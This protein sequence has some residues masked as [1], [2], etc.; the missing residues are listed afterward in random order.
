MV[1]RVRIK[2]LLD[3]DRASA[4]FKF[5]AANSV[6][7]NLKPAPDLRDASCL[8]FHLNNP[9]PSC[10]QPFARS[11]MSH[12]C[13][14]SRSPSTSLSIAAIRKSNTAIVRIPLSFGGGVTD[15]REAGKP[16]LRFPASLRPHLL[17]YTGTV[18]S[19]PFP[20][21]RIR[22]NKLL[23]QDLRSKNGY[24]VF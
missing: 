14:L 12:L 5:A 13:A 4:T 10:Q 24:R 11:L 20:S 8:R 17:K 6:G 23:A 22:D 21:P 9:S 15:F 18:T 2:E 1:W 7:K 19:L 3:T 16:C